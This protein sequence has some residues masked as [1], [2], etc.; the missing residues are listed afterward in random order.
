MNNT[1]LVVS[2]LYSPRHIEIYIGSFKLLNVDSE[3]LV[4]NHY[5]DKFAKLIKVD[6]GAGWGGRLCLFNIDTDE[7][8]LS[9]LAKKLNPN[10]GVR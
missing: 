2:H 5:G 9:D 8:F 1:F 3:P 10:Q 7:Y 4:I 6:C